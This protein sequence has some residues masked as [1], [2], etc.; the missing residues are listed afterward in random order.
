MGDSLRTT[1]AAVAAAVA[2]GAPGAD[3]ADP[4]LIL[5]AYPAEQAVL[6]RAASPV[7]EVGTFNGRRFFAGEIGGKAVVLGLTGIGLVNA[8]TTTAEA[9]DH[10]GGSGLAA[11]VFSGV[12]GGPNLGDV[13]VP[14]RW[15][16]GDGTWAVDAGMLAAAASLEVPLDPRF[17]V[18]DTA[19]T[20]ERP[21][22]LRTPLRV[23]TDPEIRVGGLGASGDPFGERAV[24]CLSSAGDL[25]GCEACGAPVNPAPGVERFLADAAPFFDPAFFLGLFASF[26]PGPGSEAVV[27]DMETAAVARLAAQRGIPFLAFRAVSDGGGDP[28]PVSAFVGFPVQFALYQQLAADNAAAVV[29]RFLEDWDP[30]G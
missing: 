22:L 12:A 29:I 17:P 21:A 9:L 14:D 13:V 1:F 27:G 25:L 8:G 2:L 3:A 20:G 6:V 19:C 11:I 7:T 24:P 4:V 23:E 30:Q 5:S 26:A 18:P 15:T 16:D 10:F 28:N